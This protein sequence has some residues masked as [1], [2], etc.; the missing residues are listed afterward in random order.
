M[1]KMGIDFG[2]VRIG[3]ALSDP[4]C[5]IS[6]PYETYTRVSFEN[7]IEYLHNLIKKQAVDMIVFGLPLQ[8]DGQEGE[9]ASHTRHFANQLAQAT[10]VEITF[11]DERLT[12]VEAE[13]ILIS[14]NVRRE[15]RKMLIDKIA[16]QII[17]QQ[18]LE[19]RR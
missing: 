8:M 12:S 7:D 11:V 10:G 14:A 3:I 6:S 19:R 18:Y 5:I 1:R 13:E 9:M 16:A 15:E 2:K 4:M 17:L